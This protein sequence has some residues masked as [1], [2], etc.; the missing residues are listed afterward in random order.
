M[1]FQISRQ[2]DVEYLG[3]ILGS[4]YVELQNRG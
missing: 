4:H 3:N 1:S 2:V